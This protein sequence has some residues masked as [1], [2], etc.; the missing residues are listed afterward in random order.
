MGAF[1][2][3]ATHNRTKNSSIPGMLS[4]FCLALLGS[5]CSGKAVALSWQHS[6]GIEVLW[7]SPLLEKPPSPLQL[8][9]GPGVCALKQKP[10][11]C[12]FP[13]RASDA[14]RAESGLKGGRGIRE[15]DCLEFSAASICLSGVPLTCACNL[16]EP[17]ASKSNPLA[18]S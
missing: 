8:E 18:A 17:W 13:P 4:S 7:V 11:G 14:P 15:P 12:R 2:P 5:R 10:S 3:A 16:S 1:R 9:V 6:L